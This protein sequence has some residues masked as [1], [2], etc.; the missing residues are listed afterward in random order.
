MK[1]LNIYNLS[2]M[3]SYANKE[4]V[5]SKTILRKKAGTI[6]MF[7][8]D[9]GQ[10]LVEHVVPYDAYLYI[11]DGTLNA[12]VEDKPHIKCK[13]D[14]FVFVPAHIPHGVIATSSC[15]MFLIM[16]KSQNK[17]Q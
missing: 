4:S 7:A 3:I 16:I 13:K 12:F 1:N 17:E 6:T 11:V 5:V 2:T 15:K 10:G 8:F 14:D 9:N